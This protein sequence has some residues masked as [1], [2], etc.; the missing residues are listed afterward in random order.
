MFSGYI[1]IIGLK[2]NKIQNQLKFCSS[3]RVSY[4]LTETD[5]QKGWGPKANFK[6]KIQKILL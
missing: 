3:W 5:P 2:I 4:I 1:N 6:N